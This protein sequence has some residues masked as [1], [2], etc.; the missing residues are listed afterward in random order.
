MKKFILMM[1]IMVGGVLSASAATETTV[2]YAISTTKTVKLNLN[3]AKTGDDWIT[4]TM[5]KTK[6]TYNGTPIYS[7]TYTDKNDGVS[8]MQFQLHGD[9][10]WES[11]EQSISSWTSESTYNGKLYVTSWVTYEPDCL[12]GDW[13]SWSPINFEDGV[14]TVSFAE[15]GSPEFKL[16][17]GS[18]WYG[19]QNEGATMFWNNSTDWTFTSSGGGKNCKIQVSA[20]GQYTFTLDATNKKIS[21][22][23]PSYTPSKVYLYNNLGLS[24]APYAYIL[25]G[26]YW[27]DNNGSGSNNEPKGVTM[28][29]VGTTNVWQA[30]YPAGAK[31]NYI[32]FTQ[33]LMDGYNNFN[34]GKA[35]YR[36]DFPA[37]TSVFVPNT[38]SSDTKN[39]TTYYSN[40][41]WHSFPTYTR[42]VTEGKFGTICLPFAATV[43]GATVFKIVSKTVDGGSNLTGI[44]LE[45]VDELEAG[46]A[47]IFKATSSKLTATLS[48][49]YADASAGYGMMGNIG[50][51]IKAPIDSYVVSGNLLRKV[52]AADVNVGK[53][54]GYVTLT[55][56]G[57]ATSR[58]ANF[59]GFNEETTGIESIANVKS[60]NVV[61]NLNGQRVTD[62]QKGLVIM[63]GKKMLRK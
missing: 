59:I 38:S 13:N 29:Q 43:T 23:F 18:T 54:K 3:L 51:T 61:Y 28:T 4:Y 63:N 35:V 57:V 46:K 11:Q 36:G 41:E 25:K 48:G 60:A 7:C 22:A 10:G 42:D 27:D 15:T 37:T 30:E 49:N 45:S 39:G 47:Y 2:Y 62:R 20:T 31:S 6:L 40:G 52:S 24:S 32:V 8:A 14:A 16:V 5:T 58:S 12:K 44:N 55:D 1:L 26:D 9:S 56:I 19:A 33:Y 50:A 17:I 21:V 34:G 53:Y